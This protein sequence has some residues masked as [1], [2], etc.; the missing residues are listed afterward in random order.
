MKEID[1][2]IELLKNQYTEPQTFRVGDFALQSTLTDEGVSV[3]DYPY[4]IPRDV[5]AF[6]SKCRDATLFED[7]EY[8]Q[9]GI[10]IL[11]PDDALK[12]TIE[13]KEYWSD[14][15][16]DSDL[17]IGRFIGDSDLLMVS[18]DKSNDYG[19]L[20]C[21]EA[22]N[23]RDKWMLVSQRFL[24]FLENYIKWTGDKYWF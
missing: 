14:M 11:S 7:K 24:D 23:K 16:K 18:C 4:E 9:W 5:V 19:Y 12:A 21:V 6:W 10:R 22:I 3:N 20:Y 1:A 2:F 17:I 8:G 13:Y 15:C